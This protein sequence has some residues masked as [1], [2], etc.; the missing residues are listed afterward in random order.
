M[1][2]NT[3]GFFSNAIYAPYDRT[4]PLRSIYNKIIRVFY[5]SVK[6]FFNHECNLKASLLTFYSLIAMVPL[7]AIIFAIAKELGFEAF[8][9][10]QILQTFSE[11]HDVISIAMRFAYSFITHI[12]SETI[13][14]IGFTFLFFSIFGL[15]GNIEK[16]L[17]T[18]WNVKKY[19]GIIRRTVNYVIT[20]IVFPAFFIASTGITI[21]INAEISQRIQQ[22]EFLKYFSEYVLPVLRYAPYVIMCVLFSFIYIYTPNSKIYIKSRI[23]AGILAGAIFQFWQILYIDF[24]VYISSYSVVYGSFAALPLFVIWM[25]VNFIIF[26]LGAEIAA[27]TENDRFFKKTSSEDQFK[28]I[29]QKQLALLVLHEITSHY[30][31]GEGSHS[32][33]HISKHL[34]IS[35]LDAREA[36]HILEKAGIIAEA[37]TSSR[38]MELYQL[39][40]NP[41]LFTIRS[42]CDLVDQN[43][44]KQARSKETST[45]NIVYSCFAKFDKSIKDSGSDLNLKDFA[46]LKTDLA[47]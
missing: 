16:T 39:I 36:L 1:K 18:I 9:E 17:N 28:M 20:L 29:T 22:Y 27:Q 13:I 38:S 19:R 37:S 21:F 40:I 42:V 46:N 4:R 23:F 11:Q 25:N 47:S 35:L 5:F 32:I 45:L 14:G 6:S 10:K 15:F 31:K 3:E 43:L 12:E 34:G 2:L 44:L 7:L 41:E 24:Q 26:L 33:E 30:L 8:L